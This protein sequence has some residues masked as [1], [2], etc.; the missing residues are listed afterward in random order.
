MSDLTCQIVNYINQETTK[1]LLHRISEKLLQIHK[2]SSVLFFSKSCN[3]KI[4]KI[5]INATMT[6]YLWPKT[7]VK[8]RVF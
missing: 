3:K 8:N 2:Q 1:K 5:L 4:H 7:L 6:V